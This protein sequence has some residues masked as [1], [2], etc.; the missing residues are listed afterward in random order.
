MLETQAIGDTA[1][2]VW[3]Y[4]HENGRSNLSAVERGIEAPKAIVDMAI[5]W[6]AREGKLQ[7]GQEKRSIQLWLSG[8]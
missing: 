3:S 2:K 1:G 6:L 7:L 5:G 8:H 4:L